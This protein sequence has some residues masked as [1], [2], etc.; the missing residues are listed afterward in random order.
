MMMDIGMSDRKRYEQAADWLLKVQAEGAPPESFAEMLAWCDADPLNKA[1]MER[2]E[3][4]W[5][6][7]GDVDGESLI[8]GVSERTPGRARLTGR[9]HW[10]DWWHERFGRYG[11]AAVG[12][13]ATLTLAL[14][15]G[16]VWWQGWSGGA[17]RAERVVTARG[18][19]EEAS[20]PDGSHVELGGRS[21]MSVIYSPQSRLV[22]AE[23]GEAFYS[24]SKDPS[25]PFIVRAGPVTVT[26]VGTAFTVRR[27]GESVSVIVTDGTVDVAA[28]NVAVRA[29][30][31]QRVRYDH[32]E[33][34][35][36]VEVASTDVATSWREGRLQFVDEP[37]RLVI[38]SVNRYSEREVL[39]S[40]PSVE[41]LRFTGT[42]FQNG[43]DTWLQG[44]A[45][46]FPVRIVP[47]DKRRVM[48]EPAN[49]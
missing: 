14:V 7:A 6:V 44:V 28:E 8:G 20:L 18:A 1:A 30:A 5:A 17:D 36:P 21:A 2:I 26:A 15:L 37:L 35:Q 32:G 41:E 40:D 13:A 38:A 12:A 39:I 19:H 16:V 4:A 24:V 31:G 48:I 43:V 3:E 49:S 34:S 22:V 42:V 10:G 11:L 25:R 29:A 33:L 9:L 46:V 45:S 27:A 23:D 47:I